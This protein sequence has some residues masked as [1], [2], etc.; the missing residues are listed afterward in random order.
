MNRFH[1]PAIRFAGAMLALSLLSITPSVLKAQTPASKPAAEP[2]A[3]P[4]DPFAPPPSTPLPP[5]MTGSTT[6]D[7]RVGLKPGLYDAGET[8]MGM[9]HLDFLKKPNA[10]QV[11]STNP[12]DPAVQKTLGLL[13]IGNSAKIPKPMR[14]VIKVPLAAP[15]PSPA[16]SEGAPSRAVHDV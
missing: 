8:A 10:F 16:I 6:N 3:E 9:E 7:P 12:D 2:A 14:L 15:C 4:D 1:A 13:G 11:N 5:G